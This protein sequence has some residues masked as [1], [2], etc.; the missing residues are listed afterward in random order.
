MYIR[1][2][3]YRG[4]ACSKVAICSCGDKPVTSS[5]S[6]INLL[7]VQRKSLLVVYTTSLSKYYWGNLLRPP[8]EMP[9]GPAYNRNTPS[10]CSVLVFKFLPTS[11]NDRQRNTHCDEGLSK[12]YLKSFHCMI[13]F[14][15]A[16]RST[17]ADKA[18]TCC[19]V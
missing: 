19:F 4:K 9:S 15:C 18:G 13:I 3:Q 2:L 5:T 12:Q 7:T 14:Q 11:Y 6:Y 1:I 17:P 16:E 10:L 8:T